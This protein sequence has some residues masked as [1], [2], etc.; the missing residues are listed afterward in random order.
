MQGLDFLTTLGELELD[1]LALWFRFMLGLEEV[2][3]SLGLG[4]IV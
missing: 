4:D 2:L 3:G 1:D